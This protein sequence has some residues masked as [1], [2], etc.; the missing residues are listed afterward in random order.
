[1]KINTLTPAQQELIPVIRDKWLDKLFGCNTRIDRAKA[2][3]GINW[4]YE[5]CGLQ[6]PEIMYVD[7]P[8]ACQY[9]YHFINSIVKANTDQVLAQAVDQ[10]GAQAWD[11]IMDQVSDQILNQA[12]AQVE[13]QVELGVED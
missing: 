10:V 12:Q 5:F 9:A 2:T 4:L 7:S 6:K 8:L 3:E 13:A 11:P 1:M